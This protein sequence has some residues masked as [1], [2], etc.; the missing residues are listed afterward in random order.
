VSKAKKFLQLPTSEKCMLFEALLLL[1]L[2]AVVLRLR[3]VRCLLPASAESFPIADHPGQGVALQQARS[4]ARMVALAA[5]WGPYRA[6][7]LKQ[8]LVVFRLLCQRGIT[9]NL[10]IGV[11]RESN[12]IKAHAWVEYQGEALNER[13]DIQQ[14]FVPFDQ[15]VPREMTWI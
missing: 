6:T 9:C 7:C 10:R 4:A 1:P 2:C 15:I 3:G 11:R 5:R 14:R 8:S 13:P 12:Q